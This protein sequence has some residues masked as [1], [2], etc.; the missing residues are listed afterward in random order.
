MNAF[1]VGALILMVGLDC[2]IAQ[3][4]KAGKPVLPPDA[5]SLKQTYDADVTK[6]VLPIRQH[7][8]SDLKSLLDKTIRADKMDEAIPIKAEVDALGSEEPAVPDPERIPEAAPALPGEAARLKQA[9]DSDV[10]RAIQPLRQRYLADLK[11]LLDRA[12]RAGQTDDAIA[13]KIEFDAVTAEGQ[14]AAN[15]IHF[16]EKRL[17]ETQWNWTNNDVEITFARNGTI[18]TPAG[19]AWAFA[20]KTVAPYAIKYR[21]SNGN[22]GTITFNAALT[23]ARIDETLNTGKKQQLKLVRIK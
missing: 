5:L 20:W 1:S 8:V 19:E 2:A 22:N 4:P 14:A 23:E 12:T 21:F 17:I 11:G 18:L 6:A 3:L 7:Y 16:F 9:Y 15:P 13:I 10:N